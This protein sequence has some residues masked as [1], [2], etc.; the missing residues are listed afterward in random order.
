MKKKCVCAHMRGDRVVVVMV[1]LH[2]LA[3]VVA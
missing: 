1:M 3:V 2:T